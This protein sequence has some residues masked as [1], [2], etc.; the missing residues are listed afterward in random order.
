MFIN[1]C[2]SFAY[3]SRVFVANKQLHNFRP[4]QQFLPEIVDEILFF[5]PLQTHDKQKYSFHNLAKLS[6]EQRF[7]LTDKRLNLTQYSSVKA[8]R[9]SEIRKPRKF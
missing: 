2:Q 8:R 6:L 5:F 9:D 3:F 1:L 4:T 7:L